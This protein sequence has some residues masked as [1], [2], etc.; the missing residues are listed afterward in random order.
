MK[1]IWAEVCGAVVC[2]LAV[3]CGGGGGGT[4]TQQ[5][6]ITGVSVTVASNT[7][8]A[9]N[10]D[11]ASVTVT[12]TGSYSMAVTWT[13]SP[14]SI[15]SI[16]SGGLFTASSTAS[17]TATI[18]ATST[19]DTTK[20]GTA[21]V[22]VTAKA[23]TV[24]V[25]PTTATIG[26]S[27][28]FAATASDGSTPTWD[29]TV[30]DSNGG[31]SDAGTISSQGVYVSPYPPPTPATIIVTAT[32]SSDSTVTGSAT[33][34]LAAPATAA[35][36]VLTVDVGNQ[37]HAINPRIY[38]VNAYLLDTQSAQAANV[39]VTRWGG[40]DTSRYN[41]Q[42]NTS[43]S[44]S[45]YYF[46]NGSGSGG[47]LPNPNGSSSFNQYVMAANGLGAK[48]LGS[49][50]VMGWVANSNT[51][52]CSYPQSTYPNQVSF[53]PQSCGDGMYPNGTNN[54]TSSGGCNIVIP[55]SQQ[56]AFAA[57]TSNAEPPPAS[58]EATLPAAGSVN[59]AWAKGTWQGGWVNS[60]VNASGFGTGN[61]GKGVAIWDLDNEPAWW[62]AVHRDVHPIPSTYDEVTFGGISTALA[63]KT[64]DS[65]AQVSGPIIDFWWNYFYSKKDIEQGWAGQG[66]IA[67]YQPWDNPTDRTAHGGVAMI[68]YYLE[69]MNQASTTY[70]VRLLDYLDIHG[71]FAGSYNGNSVAFTTAGDTG[72]Q[73][74]RMDSVRALWDPT[75]TNVSYAQPN[76]TTD[77]NYTTSCNVPLQAPEA[78]PMLHQWVN[79]VGLNGDP[80]NNYPGT[81]TAID[82]YNF[83]GLESINGAVTQADVL[84]VFGQYG[85]DLATLWPT[86]Y[87][88]QQGPGNEAFAI[89]RNYDGKDSMFGD[90]ALASCSTK[91]ALSG[92]CKPVDA[93]LQPVQNMETGQGQLS[94]Y[95]ALRASDN[96]ITVVVINKTYGPL[97]STISLLDVTSSL[98]TS[99]Q[100]Y[101]YS[102]ANLAAIQSLSAATVMPPSGAGT[103]GSLSYTF[104][105]Q[106]ITLFVIP[107]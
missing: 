41:Y 107:Q 91:T 14:S 71:Y 78:V 58:S 3:G 86:T 83:G 100:V 84:G 5:P 95:G 44:A 87:Y 56:A 54:C 39:A 23:V 47:Q 102:N 20:S 74:A 82:E 98:G 46:E 28:T 66:G 105:A 57:V 64:A 70:G 36:P 90:E 81:M 85:L 101:Q 16:S 92:A 10:T 9:G 73:M 1:R 106:S 77:S 25:T 37:L 34:T 11:Q 88:V 45:D 26:A 62:D 49:M 27:T 65:T 53:S 18:T 80:H 35:G 33:V 22:K 32:S 42:A 29:W 69:Q 97:T 52:A 75:Y 4:V 96:A 61:S 19:E 21:T 24:S 72:E 60:I 55:A 43:N 68:P 2:A 40:D 7:V 67:C 17:G 79:G 93:T 6:T 103:T 31:T 15:G 63:I 12:G 48:V 30:T 76:Y 51:S 89:Y 94:V 38:G 104:P 13:V 8:T 99:A 59:L 50:N